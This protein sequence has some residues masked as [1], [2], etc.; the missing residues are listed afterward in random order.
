M[1]FIYQEQWHPVTISRLHTISGVK[2]SYCHGDQNNYLA[3]KHSIWKAVHQLPRGSCD[4]LC[5]RTRGLTVRCKRPCTY[6]DTMQSWQMCV[7][8][9]TTH[10]YLSIYHAYYG[11]RISTNLTPGLKLGGSWNALKIN[12]S[13]GG[14]KRGQTKGNSSHLLTTNQ[15]IILFYR[16]SFII[17]NIIHQLQPLDASRLLFSHS[18]RLSHHQHLHHTRFDKRDTWFQRLRFN[19]KAFR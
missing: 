3:I 14:A 12:F 11:A 2:S 17:T 8:C 1:G 10:T 5:C 18:V 7:A 19:N 15:N 13:W 6:S 16:F 9:V 4:C